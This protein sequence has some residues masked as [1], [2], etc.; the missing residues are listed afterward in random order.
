[1]EAG[2][3]PLAIVLVAA[4]AGLFAAPLLAQDAGAALRGTVVD[5]AG[6]HVSHALVRVL[7]AGTE[8]FS[9]ARGTFA[10]SG[11]PPGAYRVQVRQV[12]YEPFDST[13][14]LGIGGASLRVALRPLA[15]RLDELTVSVA[16][17]CRDPGVPDG[18]SETA[19]AAVFTQLRENARR[20]AILADSYPFQYFVE[21]TFTNELEDGVVRIAA[22]DTVS[23][24][25]S[26]RP[27]YRPGRVVGWGLSPYGR[28]IRALQLPS[29]PDLADSAFIANH[30]FS[31]G[32][33]IEREGR[34]FLRLDFRVAEGLRAPDVDGSVDLDPDSYQL[35]TLSI[36][37]TRP[38]RAM[39]GVAS[40][41]V[42]IELTE[43]SPGLLV[44]G[45]VRSVLEPTIDARGIPPVDRYVEDQRLLR[46]R[47]LGR[48]PADSMPER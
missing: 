27:R 37:L 48:S 19:L 16:G 17:R 18:D 23:L 12:G 7:P 31:F 20:F 3:R 44:P 26:A 38:A 21:R 28:R 13:L 1:M 15:V 47:F 10:F 11:L 34:T 45:S 35:R 4:A 36:R 30:C 33:T 43:L 25:S 5:T 29:L 14:T 46:V 32:G 9:D 41:T 6:Q 24:Q 40:A 8:R 42:T 22:R 2:R 39:S